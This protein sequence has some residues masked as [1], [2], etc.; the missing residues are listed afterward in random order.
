VKVTVAVGAC[1]QI[2]RATSLASSVSMRG[3]VGAGM[4]SGSRS[5]AE[6]QVPGARRRR[7]VLLSSCQVV[8]LSV[9][10]GPGLRPAST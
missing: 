5:R 10:A 2:S 6:R 9:V 4:V 3:T 7:R 1:A 8:A